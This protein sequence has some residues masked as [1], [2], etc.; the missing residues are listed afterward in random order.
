MLHA[1]DCSDDLGYMD[2]MEL[3]HVPRAENLQ[4][5]SIQG[6]IAMKAIQFHD[7]F[8]EARIY[9]FATLSD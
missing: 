2:L 6:Q 4:I 8:G 5:P 9:N 3:W 7:S 1:K